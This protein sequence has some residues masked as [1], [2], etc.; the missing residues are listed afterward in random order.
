MRARPAFIALLVVCV[1]PPFA[2]AQGGPVVFKG[3]EVTPLGNATLSVAPVVAGEAALFPNK[4]FVGG[5]SFSGND[6]FRMHIGGG[7]GAHI[8]CQDLV[9]SLP[10]GSSVEFRTNDTA[11][12]NPCCL[13][14]L[15]AAG[16]VTVTP[17]FSPLGA[18]SY[19][20]EIWNDGAPVAGADG[21]MGGMSTS[22]LPVAF[23]VDLESVIA[24]LPDPFS[25]PA[26]LRFGLSQGFLLRWAG[27]VTLMDAVGT[28]L[29]TGDELR[30]FPEGTAMLASVG[31][32][33]VLVAA[34]SPAGPYTLGVDDLAQQM[35]G[36]LR[37]G[38]GG[39]VISVD[40][41]KATMTLPA[42]VAGG[43]QVDVDA[44][45]SAECLIWDIKDGCSAGDTDEFSVTG[46]LLT[47]G[48]AQIGRVA[49]VHNGSQWT[50]TPDFSGSGSP[51]A[52][53]ELFDD[54]GNLMGINPCCFEFSIMTTQ[55]AFE[56]GVESNN[57]L[58]LLLG[59]ATPVTVDLPGVGTVPNVS[60]IKMHSNATRKHRFFVIVD[61]THLS[62]V[63]GDFAVQYEPNV[64]SLAQASTMVSFASR[65]AAYG[66]RFHDGVVIN[67]MGMSG[68][69]GVDVQPMPA[70]DQFGVEWAP[71]G[72]PS[73]TMA[74]T[75]W[76]FVSRLASD[77]TPVRR[78]SV[79]LISNG[80]MVA[81]HVDPEQSSTTEYRVIL[82]NGGAVVAEYVHT[83]LATAF[84]E[85]PD[86]PAGAGFQVLQYPDRP[87]SMWIDLGYEM[88][89][90]TPG[91]PVS[92]N[93]AAFP[94][95][96][97]DL[98]EILADKTSFQ[99]QPVETA[100]SGRAINLATL[101]VTDREP[102]LTGIGAT[103][104][105]AHS[106]LRP[107][108][109]NPFNPQTTLAFDLA[110]SGV[111]SLKIYAVDGRLVATVQEG[112]LRAGRHAY[113]WNGRNGRGQPVA[114][115]VYLAE[116][117]TPDGMQR[118]KLNLLK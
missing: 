14:G 15:P 39:A 91:G 95:T 51:D 5:L 108:Y 33:D 66:K 83:S 65:G 56:T 25:L 62:A 42:G 9:A 31:S 97:A 74:E 69:D 29:G 54:S 21:V 111:V 92:Q 24:P 117:R 13:V 61:R 64:F 110:T 49:S 113:T 59:F 43:M 35:S 118:A 109:P 73:A 80:S 57:S 116:L 4:L 87:W 68:N 48:Q 82:R 93:R 2:A 115:G 1:F 40:M 8:Q 99:G 89:V 41:G 78:M 105:S 77:P 23:S 53:V 70:Q 98:I 102:R 101:V 114:S 71:L 19:R 30:M 28:A 27:D 7:T 34:L 10:L 52:A 96:K 6:G 58:A 26:T 11:G 38:G 44:E 94:L 18:T 84:A 107:A 72:P 100:L 106:V 37:R 20:V 112:T 22:A 46:E 79:H 17:D 3:T 85:L 16:A 103:P 47:G 63:G 60:R 90:V 86:W 55:W 75:D 67:A 45:Q 88:D 12:I 81:A 50:V 76:A 104:Q 32:V 36:H